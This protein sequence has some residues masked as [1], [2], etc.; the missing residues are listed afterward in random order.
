MLEARIKARA[1][2]IRI[3]GYS[4]KAYTGQ[5]VKRYTDQGD[6]NDQI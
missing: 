6:Q 4:S 5:G 1:S 3:K 2:R